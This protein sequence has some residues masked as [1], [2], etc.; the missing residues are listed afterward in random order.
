MT[1]RSRPLTRQER[2]RSGA[3]AR[4]SQEDWTEMTS[5]ANAA[6][7][8]VGN[9]DRWRGIARESN[10]R[11][12]ESQVDRLAKLLMQA[13]FAD[14]GR[15]SGRARRDQSRRPDAGLASPLALRRLPSVCDAA[16]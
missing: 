14:L 2:G 1:K 7:S 11:L 16:E 4:L 12:T 8:H 13:Y 15:R 6:S 3:I 9:M 5:T 10:P